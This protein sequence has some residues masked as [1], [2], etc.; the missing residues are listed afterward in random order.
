MPPLPGI[1]GARL[2]GARKRAPKWKNNEVPE[3]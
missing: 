1:P 2:D 3:P